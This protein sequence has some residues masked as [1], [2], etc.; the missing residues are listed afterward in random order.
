VRN[1]SAPGKK[2][3]FCFFGG[4]NCRTNFS[5]EK[6]QWPHSICLQLRAWLIHDKIKTEYIQEKE[7]CEIRLWGKW[8]KMNVRSK[9]TKLM[10]RLYIEGE[11]GIFEI[12]VLVTFPTCTQLIYS[13]QSHSR[14]ESYSTFCPPIFLP[15]RHYLVLASTK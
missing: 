11:W 8:I 15:P 5:E 1:A 3:L 2:T 14:L 6:L 4:E 13:I 7:S 9:Q 12:R 10:I